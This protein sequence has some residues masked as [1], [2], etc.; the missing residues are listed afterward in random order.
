MVTRRIPHFDL[1]QIAE[2][3]QCFRLNRE[4]P[5]WRLIAHG[6]VLQMRQHGETVQF[7]CTQKAFEEIWRGYFDL[8]TDY[9]TF[10]ASPA[11][12]DSY[13]AGAAA[14]GSGIRILRQDPWETLVTFL[15]SQRKNI[16]AI[17]S[18]VEALCTRFGKPIH[19]GKETFYAFPTAKTLARCSPEDL[20]ACSLG[21][22]VPYVADAAKKVACGALDLPSLNGLDNDALQEAL[23]RIHGVGIKVASCV[24]LFGYHR[25]DCFPRDVWINRV[26]ETHYGGRFDPLRYKGF[27]G[28]IQQ[29]LFYYARN[30][31][32]D[33]R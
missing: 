5:N 8:D 28:V 18:A 17:R 33:H 19:R 23:L 9:G 10:L 24:A 31:K 22:R 1:A 32:I 20:S 16:S 11:P 4:G 29:Y 14:Y 6:K 3:G 25:L 21:Y 2:S 12:D 30:E 27:A 15:L 7:L 26:L 13:L